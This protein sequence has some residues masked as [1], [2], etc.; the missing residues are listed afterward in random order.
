MSGTKR[1]LLAV[2]V[3]CLGVRCIIVPAR[4]RVYVPPPPATVV[5]TPPPAHYAT[6]PPAQPVPPPPPPPR[7]LSEGEAI[8]IGVRYC[9]SRAYPCDLQESHLT[10]DGAV[11]KVKFKVRGYGEGGHV[12]MDID[13]RNGSMIAGTPGQSYW[14]EPSSDAATPAGPGA[15]WLA[16]ATTEPLRAPLAEGT[17]RTVMAQEA[18]GASVEVQP[19][20][21]T[22][23]SPPLVVTAMA[24]ES[25]VPWLESWKLKSP[26]ASSS[27]T[28]RAP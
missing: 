14:P 23:K 15:P 21:R 24:L 13:A 11:W 22:E 7:I 8:N 28:V 17:K 3:L 20:P 18:P 5:V 9:Q 12:H 4:Q 25:T 2:A 26:L 27:P 6:P 10:G 1:L 16:V 19:L